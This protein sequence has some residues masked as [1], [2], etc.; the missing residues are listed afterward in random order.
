M[1]LFIQQPRPILPLI[2]LHDRCLC[3]TPTFKPKQL[4]WLP[5]YKPYNAFKMIDNN[6][7]GH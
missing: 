4:S 7:I 3:A 1:V 5:Q 6:I 2:A